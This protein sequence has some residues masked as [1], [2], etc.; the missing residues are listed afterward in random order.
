[1]KT[2]TKYIYNQ[3]AANQL[4]LNDAK[5]MLKELQDR[6][7]SQGNEI[8]IIGMACRFP[9]AAN[10]DEFWDNL[11]NKINCIDDFP[12]SRRETCRNLSD[13]SL[14]ARMLFGNPRDHEEQGQSIYVKGGYLPEIDK[15]DA[16][17]FRI[18]P[19]EAMH[20]DPLQRIFLETAYEAMEDAGYGGRNLYGTKVGVFVG[21]DHTYSTSTIY[22]E[23]TEP[24]EMKLTGSWAGILASRLGYIYNFRGPCMVI[25]TACSSGLVALHEACRALINKECEAAIA[26]GIQIRLFPNIKGIHS[27]MEMFESNDDSVR[28][29]DKD[30]GG[31]VWGEGAGALI[32]KPLDKAIADHDH[33]YA[34]IKGSAINNCG[35]SSGITAPNVEAQKEVIIK[36]WK[37]A[38]IDPETISYIEAHSIGTSLGDPIEIKGITAAF[39]EFTT[40]KQFCGIGSVKTNLGHL[41]AASGIASVIKVVLAL[42]NNEIPPLINFRSPNPYINFLNSPV[43]VND[44]SRPWNATIG[45]PRRAGVGA[46]GFS[47]TNCHVIIEEPPA[48]AGKETVLA[49]NQPGIFTISARN[50]NVLQDLLKRYHVFLG[51]ARESDLGNIC[52]TANT[53]RGHHH[54][55][56]ALVVTGIDNLKQKIAKLI[57][58][59]LQKVR[60]PGVYFGV[61]HMVPDHK[62][63]HAENEFTEY[64]R[65]QFNTTAN[66]KLNEYAAT[67]TSGVLSP[68]FTE[69]LCRLYI[70]G[71]DIDWNELYKDQGFIKMSLPVYPL[72]RIPVWAAP[73]IVRIEGLQIEDQVLKMVDGELK[74]VKAADYQGQPAK[75]SENTGLSKERQYPKAVVTGIDNYDEAETIYILAQ[76]WARVL[77]VNEIS[78]ERSFYDMGGDSILASELLK[79]IGREY[80]DILSSTDLFSYSTVNELAKVIDQKGG[81]AKRNELITAQRIDDPPSNQRDQEVP[82][83]TAAAMTAQTPVKPEADP[84]EKMEAEASVAGLEPS[85]SDQVKKLERFPDIYKIEDLWTTDQVF[86]ND[87][88]EAKELKLNL[89]RE[90]TIALHRCLPLQIVLSDEKLHPWYYEHFVNIFSQIQGDGFLKLDYL[91]EFGN[92]R[93]VIN[94][95]SLSAAH[96]AE[97]KDIISFIIDNIDRGNYLNVCVDEY[98]LPRKMRSQ[99]THFIYLELIYG[100]DNQKQELKSVGFNAEN[101]IDKLTFTYDEFRNAYEKG[102]AYYRESAPWTSHGAVELFYSNGFDRQ[103]PFKVKSFLDRLY[104]YLHSSQ[105]KEIVYYWSLKD[106]QVEYGFK[107]HDVVLAYLEKLMQGIMI[108]DYRALHLL[109]EHKNGL[110]KRF[111]YIIK[112]YGITGRMIQLND[113]YLNVVE[114]FNTIRLKFL[115]LENRFSY[116]TPGPGDR[117]FAKV[118]LEQMIKML[119]SGKE[120][121]YTILMEIYEILNSLRLTDDEKNT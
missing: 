34:V 43:Y 2:V 94:E 27:T 86:Q 21:E 33:I 112:R 10:P 119:K 110:A 3:V 106:E 18:P 85:I 23:V 5:T 95:V 111:A 8:A 71:A 83:E 117:K 73:N 13:K 36:A 20:M 66:Q 91:E 44:C 16:A 31:T 105:E 121:D 60:E 87:G 65:R 76:I 70:K 68:E 84:V 32:V 54:F 49:S 1:M 12:P 7:S 25:D 9:K 41:V 113:A 88:P 118:Q 116:R 108:M 82:A 114:Q 61:Y 100:Y 46:F 26:G 115:E 19:R 120:K 62:V 14:L 102:K 97:Q 90:V 37:E 58:M 42:K 59:D 11:I 101:I 92:F 51:R 28:T 103:Y 89:Q 29:F 80:P 79:E 53:G 48:V 17:F 63:N 98:Y 39:E 6:A 55:R 56:I 35:A 75:I 99:K 4:S 109:Y 67:A 47:G 107:V 52:F 74:L 24:D 22:K 93:S 64:E 72:E 69:E 104:S 57:D 40:K 30:A 77:G 50:I 81:N 96:M 78:V 45:L 38:K 15:F